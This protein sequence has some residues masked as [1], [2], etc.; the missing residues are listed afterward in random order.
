MV[1]RNQYAMTEYHHSNSML[2]HS[3]VMIQALHNST[4][5]N[6]HQ[7]LVRQDTSFDLLSTSQNK[8]MQVEGYDLPIN[9]VPDGSDMLF[10]N[11]YNQYLI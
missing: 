9:I 2:H 5:C 6:T 10:V 7:T 11:P 4:S 8:L 3:I 1:Q